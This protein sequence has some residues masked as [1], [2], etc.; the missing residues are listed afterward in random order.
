MRAKRIHVNLR[1]LM[2]RYAIVGGDVMCAA[3][4]GS[5]KTGAFCLPIIQ[6]VWEVLNS[7]I[8]PEKKKASLS[9]CKLNRDG[10]P[11]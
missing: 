4:T 1:S 11:W 5:G 9:Y 6:T 8:N 10:M 7:K 3:E 2:Q